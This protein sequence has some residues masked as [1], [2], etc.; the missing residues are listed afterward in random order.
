MK[1][2]QLVG[3]RAYEYMYEYVR[4][5]EAQARRVSLSGRAVRLNTQ[6]RGVPDVRSRFE[7][8]AYRRRTQV[9]DTY[10]NSNSQESNS[11]RASCTG[12]CF[13]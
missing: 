3:S 1:F 6:S 13:N 7:L 8:S 2:D 11:T 12:T 4:T 5:L 9:A 10:A